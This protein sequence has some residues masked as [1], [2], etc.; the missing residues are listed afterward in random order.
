MK[1]ILFQ[2]LLNYF[3]S[4]RFLGLKKHFW[5]LLYNWQEIKKK[6]IFFFYFNQDV[7][8]WF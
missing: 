4:K 7:K 1:S 3:G 2:C 5:I 6:N 8:G